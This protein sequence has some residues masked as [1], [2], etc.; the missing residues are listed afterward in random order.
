L[1]SIFAVGASLLASPTR[2]QE[3]W[4]SPLDQNALPGQV[5]LWSARIGQGLVGVMQPVRVTL[6]STGTVTVYNGGPQTGIDLPAPGQF[7]VGV[8]FIYRLKISNLPEFRGVE[9]YPTIEIIDRLHPPTGREQEF[10][11]PISFTADE[12]QSV[13]EGRMVTKVVYLEQPQFAA[14]GDLSAAMLSR[15]LPPDR[16]LLVEAD[17]LGRPMILI[18]LGSR[19]PSESRGDIA[20][21]GPPAPLSVVPQ[22]PR[23]SDA[24]AGRAVVRDKAT[25]FTPADPRA[26]IEGENAIRL[27]SRRGLSHPTLPR[28]YAMLE[29]ALPPWE[30]FPDEYLLDGGDRGLPVHET[31]GTR[32]GL[33]T[34]D[35]VAEYADKTGQRHI[36]PTN[37]VAIYAPRFGDV[38]TATGAE[39][40][41]TVTGLASAVDLAKGE[42]LRNRVMATHHAQP[43]PSQSVRVRSRASGFETENSQVGVNQRVKLSENLEMAGSV[44]DVQNQIAAGM[45]QSEAARVAKAR[46]AAHSWTRSEFPIVT[47]SL[48]GAQQITAHFI[49]N[50]LVGVEDR[51]KPGRLQIVKLADKQTAVPGE[52]VRFT[53]EYENVG[54]IEL[55]NVQI[56]DNL[57]PRLGYLESTGTSNRAADL[58]VSDNGE[59]SAILTWTLKGPLPG[60]TKGT[61]TFEARVR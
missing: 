43:M 2:A 9:L 23:Q 1:A 18:R 52:T 59:G 17:R 35:A 44:E 21:F 33:D 30:R 5:G 32:E 26:Q 12:I 27:A 47:A 13:I 50:E 54:D 48:S 10:P 42:G 37:R 61:V 55:S 8:G 29:P 41:V 19:A 40:G 38:G 7:N 4:Y 36:V 6:P 51:R 34:E 58:V 60:R 11:V 22:Q 24:D 20:F 49:V 16:N 46:A 57:T 56:I 28:P 15:V 25:T 31:P 53:I 14:V 3:G 45:R 39:A